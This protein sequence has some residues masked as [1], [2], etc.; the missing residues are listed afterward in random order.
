MIKFYV[1]RK[2]GEKNFVLLRELKTINDIEYFILYV[3][4]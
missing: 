4:E 3:F 1:I 2:I